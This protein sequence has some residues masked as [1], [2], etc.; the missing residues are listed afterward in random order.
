LLKFIY[1]KIIIYLIMSLNIEQITLKNIRFLYK[2]EIIIGIDTIY[3]EKMD[4]C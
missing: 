1:N 4:F 3:D 2:N